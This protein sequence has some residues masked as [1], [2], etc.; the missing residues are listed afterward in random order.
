[1]MKISLIR[2]GRPAVDFETRIAGCDLGAWVAR[3]DAAGIDTALSPPEAFWH[4]LA[5]CER[6]FASPTR[7]AWDSAVVLGR[8]GP[9]GTVTRPVALDEAREAPLPPQLYFP[10]AVKPLTLVVMAR[11][12]WLAGWAAAKEDKGQVKARAGRLAGRL[13]TEAATATGGHVALVGHGY[14]NIFT[15]KR[16]KA[17]GWREEVK[18]GN[19]YWACTVM[20]KG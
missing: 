8:R 19:G 18:R 10:V 4:A 7:R 20:V 14:M 5:D 12:L 11:T 13:E 2:H 15:R 3:Y 16:L 1:M 9:E 6:V 17:A